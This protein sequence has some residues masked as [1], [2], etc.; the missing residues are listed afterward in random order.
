MK[1]SEIKKKLSLRAEEMSLFLFDLLC[2]SEAISLLFRRLL[3]QKAPRN[4]SKKKS[5]FTRKFVTKAITVKNFAALNL[6]Q[7]DGGQKNV[8]H[9]LHRINV[10]MPNAIF[11]SFIFLS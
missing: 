11:L 1:T 8:C 10:I 3:R 6:R 4:D 7:K 9:L 5:P 2:R